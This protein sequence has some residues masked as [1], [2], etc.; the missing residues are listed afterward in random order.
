MKKKRE[1]K[2][3]NKK[4]KLKGRGIIHHVNGFIIESIHLLTISQRITWPGWKSSL[5]MQALMFKI[6]NVSF[7][8]LVLF[9][10]ILNA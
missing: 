8:V 2:S 6:E 7:I 10:K 9:V 4:S 1:K 3:E 5:N